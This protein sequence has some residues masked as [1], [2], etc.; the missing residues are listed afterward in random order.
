MLSLLS[1]WGAFLEVTLYRD[2]IT[3]FL[4]GAPCGRRPVA[5]VSGKR[6]LGT[7]DLNLLTEKSAFSISAVTVAPL[8]YESHLSRILH[9]TSLDHMHWINLDHHK[10]TFTTLS[11]SSKF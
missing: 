4:K 2:A 8:E 11:N 10:I 3:H 7:Q 5:I 1:D 9:H 6:M